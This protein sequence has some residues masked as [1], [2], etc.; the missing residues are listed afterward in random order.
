MVKAQAFHKQLFQNQLTIRYEILVKEPE[1]IIDKI[2]T[3]FNL[4]SNID[5]VK[6]VISRPSYSSIKNTYEI[7]RLI[8]QKA[9]NMIREACRLWDYEF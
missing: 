6:Q 2:A 4:I 9:I 8:D 7:K 5:L 1:L 3:K